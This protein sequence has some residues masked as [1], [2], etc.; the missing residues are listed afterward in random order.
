MNSHISPT[1]NLCPNWKDLLC[2]MAKEILK[3]PGGTQLKLVRDESFARTKKGAILFIVQI[4]GK[5]PRFINLASA[6]EKLAKV[7]AMT[8]GTFRQMKV[9]DLIDVEEFKFRVREFFELNNRFIFWEETHEKAYEILLKGRAIDLQRSA[10]ALR[11]LKNPVW[12]AKIG[13]NETYVW[14]I[15]GMFTALNNAAKANNLDMRDE[16]MSWAQSR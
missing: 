1:A 5:R 13:K 7:S 4:L 8:K 15:N 2:K 16:I 6:L 3:V 9:V 10:K 12:A 11:K 14:W